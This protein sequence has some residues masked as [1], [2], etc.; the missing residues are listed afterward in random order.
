MNARFKD[1]LNQLL[2]YIKQNK[3]NKGGFVTANLDNIKDLLYRVIH[4]CSNV[5][6][7]PDN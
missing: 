5:K 1:F 2:F 4:Y 3:D 6:P 7:Y